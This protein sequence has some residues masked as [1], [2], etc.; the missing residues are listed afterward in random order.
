[1]VERA[2]WTVI[3]GGE[4]ERDFASIVEWTARTFGTRQARA[5]AESLKALLGAFRQGPHLSGTRRRN[6]IGDGVCTLHLRALGL[7]GRH[8]ALYREKDGNT[9]L[10][11]RILHDSMDL[12]RHVPP[13]A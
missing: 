12:A 11:L 2:A 13:D 3:L 10:V 5:Y 1:M 9:I 4:A 6:E 7:K 8:F